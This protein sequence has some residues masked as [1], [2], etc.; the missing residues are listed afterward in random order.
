MP[1]VFPY[2]GRDVP[3]I[4]VIKKPHQFLGSPLRHLGGKRPEPLAAGGVL[5]GSPVLPNKVSAGR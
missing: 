4:Q 2:A 5:E 1:S 3:F